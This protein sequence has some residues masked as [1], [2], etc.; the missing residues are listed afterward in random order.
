MIGK[1]HGIIDNRV[2]Q[3]HRK[4]LAAITC[5]CV[6]PLHIAVKATSNQTE[7]LIPR[8]MT[9]RVVEFLEKIDVCHR[10]TK[11]LTILCGGC[12]LCKEDFVKRFAVGNAGQLIGHG[13]IA[14]LGQVGPKFFHF[15]FRLGEAF[16]ECAGAFLHLLGCRNHGVYNPTKVCCRDFTGKGGADPLHAFTEH[17]GVAAGGRN[18]FQNAVH[19]TGQLIAGGCCGIRKGDLR[20]VNELIQLMN[21]GF[22]ERLP[23]AKSIIDPGREGRVL[24]GGV[25][26]PDTV[27]RGG[28]VN[29]IFV[30]K[31]HGF[32]AITGCR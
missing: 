21:E 20:R 2:W 27:G 10:Q 1:F 29:L 22:I 11:W 4:L 6:L 24:A 25:R 5:G 3:D 17:I 15:L 31:T 12:H 14:R 16:F 32:H 7:N 26:I 28:R 13:F 19:F 9:K 18:N 30:H 8:L 23:F